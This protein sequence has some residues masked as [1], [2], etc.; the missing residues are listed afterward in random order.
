MRLKKIIIGP[1]GVILVIALGLTWNAFRSIHAAEAS[2]A[3][4]ARKRAGLVAEIHH[5]ERRIAATE[6]DQVDL[7][8][9]LDHLGMPKPISPP[10]KSP[11]G[12]LTQFIADDPKLQ[13]LYFASRHAALAKSYGPFFRALGLSPTQIDK[14]DAIIIDREEQSQDLIAAGL[15][16]GLPVGDQAVA[17]LRQKMENDSRTALTDLLGETGYQLLRQYEGT[18]PVRAVVQQLAGA[19]A[20]EGMPLTPQQAEQLT[21]VLANASTGYQSSETADFLATASVNW[22][23][24]DEQAKGILSPAQLNF[25][26]QFEPLGGGPS[27]FA[28]QLVNL[29]DQAK[30]AGAAATSTPPAKPPNG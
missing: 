28:L 4:V 7:Q 23:A 8:V 10:K 30:K 15:S 17:A 19:T 3:T 21:Q 27:R 2:L 5:L 16:Q 29:F 12:S 6:N 18:Q 22:N 25:F 24:A 26:K 1:I 9:T 13:A 20:L 14:F 11:S